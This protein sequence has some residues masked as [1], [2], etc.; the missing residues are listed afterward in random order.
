MT[1]KDQIE[2]FAQSLL[3]LDAKKK[4]VLGAA[5]VITIAAAIFASAQFSKPVTAP[6]Y[7]NLSREDLNA[8]SRILS[9]NGIDFV[10][11]AENGSIEVAT[12]RTAGARMLLAEHGLPSSQESGYELFDR[13]NTLGLTSFMQ[14]VTN[15]RAIEGELVRTIQMINGVNS[16]RVH[17]VMEEKNLFRRNRG[18]PPS[19]SVVLK[20]YGKIPTRSVNAI[21]HMVSAAVPGLDASNVTI[22]GSDGTLMT[23][24][25][26]IAGG[27]T[28]LVELEKEFET[29]IE[30]K[31]ASALGA[32]LGHENLRVSA[33]VKLNSDKRRVDETVFDPDSRVE[34][35][36]QV[37]REVGTTENKETARPAAVDQNLPEEE[38]GGGAG[39]SSSEN[40]ER[41]EEL[42]N[43]EINE[44]KISVVSDGYKIET[45]SV[46]LLVNKNR[47]TEILG[48]SPAQTDIDA[49][50]AELEEIVKAAV[51]I[52]DDRGDKVM[53]NLVEFMP[54]ESGGEQ[55]ETSSMANFFAIH[56]GAIL[57]T[58]GLITAAVLFALLG[59]R[60]VISF[61]SKDSGGG[62]GG[63]PVAL[64]FEGNDAFAADPDALNDPNLL[65]SMN[66]GGSLPGGGGGDPFGNPSNPFGEE[67]PVDL[68]QVVERESRI[69]DQLSDLVD[70]SEDRAAIALKHWLQEDNNVRTV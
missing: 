8:M 3:A 4:L 16:A 65:A 55:V 30:T 9:E 46:A 44:K 35:S 37:V 32:H 67:P 27:S 51:S 40:S 42:T 69:K 61:L 6:L 57:N 47:L 13:V 19:A 28:K 41:R 33:F 39:Q 59:I 14:G 29:D 17:L 70:Q 66:S 50:V 7:S 21:R 52:S 43:Y 62:G 22:V 48:G 10:V 58:L 34:R 5:I 38:I 36:V 24:K 2:N 60:P 11:M 54:V 18:A 26:D 12:A 68:N 56:F 25:D 15:K 64:P 1:L 20:T 63:G 49:K 31:I 53:V 45:L 23:T